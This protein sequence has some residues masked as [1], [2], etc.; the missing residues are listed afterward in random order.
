M[1]DIST[2]ATEMINID[3]IFRPAWAVYEDGGVQILWAT[4]AM[5]I[6]SDGLERTLDDVLAKFLDLGRLR[7]E[8]PNDD[9]P[10]LWAME[11]YSLEAMH[12]DPRLAVHLWN[13]QVLRL[14][15]LQKAELVRDDWGK[16][17][18]RMNTFEFWPRDAETAVPVVIHGSHPLGYW[19]EIEVPALGKKYH[20]R[21]GTTLHGFINTLRNAADDVLYEGP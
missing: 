9:E 7:S 6:P 13:T 17:S 11:H 14:E 2:R 4:E 19:F 5:S 20:V 15:H 16:P 8:L 1:A 12:I 21:N 3:G 18:L 10:I